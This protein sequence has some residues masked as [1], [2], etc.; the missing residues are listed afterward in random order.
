MLIYDSKKA[1]PK[2]FNPKNKDL[3]K[4]VGRC[5]CGKRIRGKEAVPHPDPFDSEIDDDNTPI[6]QCEDCDYA[7]EDE[8]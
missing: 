5:H 1:N 4:L 6:V 8:I 2:T 3:R 7:S